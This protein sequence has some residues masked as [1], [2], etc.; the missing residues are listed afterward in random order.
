MLPKI[1]FFFQHPHKTMFYKHKTE[2]FI[3]KTTILYNRL[4][5]FMKFIRKKNIPL[6]RVWRIVAN[7]Q[8]VTAVNTLYIIER[9]SIRKIFI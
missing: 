3:I 7:T 2:I 6:R 5:F 9:L 4:P 8:G 1:R